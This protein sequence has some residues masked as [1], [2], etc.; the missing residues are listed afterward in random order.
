MKPRNNFLA[1]WVGTL[2]CFKVFKNISLLHFVC[3]LGIAQLRSRTI[4]FIPGYALFVM[5]ASFLLPLIIIIAAYGS[6][7]RVARRHARNQTHGPSAISHQHYKA[8]KS[9]LKAAKTIAFVIGTFLCCWAPFIFVS[10]CFVYCESIN[11][12]GASVAKWLSYLNAVLNP[13]VYTCVDKHLR[14]LVRKRLSLCLAKTVWSNSTEERSTHKTYSEYS[15]PL[16]L[17]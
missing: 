5:S 7:Y 16:T 14:G 13:V 1:I 4:F 11:P 10:I 2:S 17:V 8:F 6:M 9:N 15:L 3:F 12:D